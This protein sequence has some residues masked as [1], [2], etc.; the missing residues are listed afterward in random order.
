LQVR[1]ARHFYLIGAPHD[2]T[3]RTARARI[4]RVF[5]IAWLSQRAR[6][7]ATAHG[8]TLAAFLRFLSIGVAFKIIS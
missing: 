5:C 1:F 6:F 7:I 2:A 3:T 4:L 8:R